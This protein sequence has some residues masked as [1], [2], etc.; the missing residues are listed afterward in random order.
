MTMRINLWGRFKENVFR[1][2]VFTMTIAVG[3]KEAMGNWR[4]VGRWE[5]LMEDDPRGDGRGWNQ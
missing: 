4:G 1:I 2:K 3:K 5:W